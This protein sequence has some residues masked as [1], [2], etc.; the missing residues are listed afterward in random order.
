MKTILAACLAVLASGVISGVIAQEE[1]KSPVKRYPKLPYKAFISKAVGKTGTLWKPALPQG[2]K[3][4]DFDLVEVLETLRERKVVYVE[5]DYLKIVS[6][7][8]PLKVTPTTRPR[9]KESMKML[10]ATYPPFKGKYP[11][12]TREQVPHLFAFHCHRMMVDAWK[13]FGSDM[14][15]YEQYFRDYKHGPYMRQKGKFEIYLFARKKT[16]FT[17]ADRFTGRCYTDGLRHRAPVTDVLALL[18]PPSPSGGVKS[19][20]GWTSVIIHNFAHNVLM[21]EIKNSYVIPTWL[22]IG[23]AHWMERREGDYNTYCFDETGDPPQFTQGDWMTKIRMMVVAG[24]APDFAE[25]FLC[26]NLAEVD[27]TIHGICYGLADYIIRERVE[28]IK[29]FCYIRRESKGTLRQHFR[30]VW[31]E[32]PETFWERCLEWIKVNYTKKG[33]LALKEPPRVLQDAKGVEVQ[34]Q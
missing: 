24:R 19:I 28:G 16:Y 27:G 29:P 22:D 2:Q 31:Q 6:T 33:R 26:K 21:S 3:L 14:S 12:I 17:F 30:Q 9:I 25:F 20:D 18:L 4:L 1:A 32:S 34:K 10:S 23:F 15:T 11:V 13:I 8:P 7:V 5:T